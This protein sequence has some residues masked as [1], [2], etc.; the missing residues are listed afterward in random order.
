MENLSII[1]GKNLATLRKA[2]GITQQ[3]LAREINYSDKSISKWELGYALPSVDVLQDFATFYGVTIDYLV[4]EQTE[5]ALQ[6]VAKQDEEDERVKRVNQ[7]IVIA[8]TVAFVFL[9]AICVFFSGYY[10]PF[11]T[12]PEG[13]P[14]PQ[15]LW[16]VFVW[17]VPVSIFLVFLET[18]H[19]YHRR[20][21]NVIM[22]SAFTWT[23]LIAFCIQFQYYNEEPEVIWYILVVGI[24]LQIILILW[25]NFK[26]RRKVK[27]SK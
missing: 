19:Y 22:A 17:M 15:G 24:P 16:V 11:K 26:P 1:V 9:V 14:A 23:L 27:Q 10:N 18:W 3:E 8:M 7:I 6:S 12:R 21:L 13:T 4:K 2:K 25:G 5:E 20:L